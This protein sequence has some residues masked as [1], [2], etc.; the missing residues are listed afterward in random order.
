MSY[1]T[2]LNNRIM[3][4]ENKIMKL[5]V[6]KNHALEELTILKHARDTRLKRNTKNTTLCFG[7]KTRLGPC[8]FRFK[9]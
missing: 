8:L 2:E 6:E 4:Y 3:E 1:K 7:N 5:N 9:N